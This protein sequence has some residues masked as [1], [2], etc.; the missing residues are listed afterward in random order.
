MLVT[1]Q[2]LARVL[3]RCLAEAG[4]GQVAQQAQQAHQPQP[5]GEGGG[6]GGGQS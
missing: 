6:Q 2:K 5:G 3:E 1:P 4:I